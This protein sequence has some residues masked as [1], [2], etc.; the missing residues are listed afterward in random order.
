MQAERQKAG[1]ERV[2]R[3]E[4]VERAERQILKYEPHKRF[5]LFDI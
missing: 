5:I 3:V 2:E 1:T 4:R